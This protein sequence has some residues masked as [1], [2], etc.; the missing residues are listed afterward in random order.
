MKHANMVTYN[1]ILFLPK[2]FVAPLHPRGPQELGGSGSLTAWTPGFYATEYYN[3][4]TVTS[5]LSLG[6]SDC[7]PSSAAMSQGQHNVL[8]SCHQLRQSSI[9]S[10]LIYALDLAVLF[11]QVINSHVT[12]SK[13]ADGHSMDSDCRWQLTFDNWWIPRSASQH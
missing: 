8:T 11:S 12:S 2:F 4:L 10:C 7:W 13:D 3:F 6:F 9:D 5:G 1:T